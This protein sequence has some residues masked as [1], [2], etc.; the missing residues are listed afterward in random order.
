MD[1]GGP[2]NLGRFLRSLGP[3]FQVALA[4]VAAHFLATSLG[5][6]SA[7]SQARGTAYWRLGQKC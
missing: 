1:L 7:S 3:N 4:G 6:S 2:I 5:D